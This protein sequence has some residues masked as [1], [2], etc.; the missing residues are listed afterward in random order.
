M[1]TEI[2]GRETASAQHKS[3]RALVGQCVLSGDVPAGVDRAGTRGSSAGEI[4]CDVTFAAQ[5]KA[6]AALVGQGV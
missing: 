3:M 5:H 4:D 1:A 6:M 2:D